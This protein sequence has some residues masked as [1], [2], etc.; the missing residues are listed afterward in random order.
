MAPKPRLAATEMTVANS[1]VA[2]TTRPAGPSI[3]APKSGFS[4]TESS[5][6]SFFLKVK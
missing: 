1:A 6:R 5:A 4:V 3:L 2:S